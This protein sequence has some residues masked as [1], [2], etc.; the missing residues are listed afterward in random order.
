MFRLVV[1]ESTT[2][3]Y[4]PVLKRRIMV[5]KTGKIIYDWKMTMRKKCFRKD[6]VWPM[7]YSFLS[8]PENV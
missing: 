4:Y 6:N 8:L 1:P 3:V 2:E 7:T 5:D